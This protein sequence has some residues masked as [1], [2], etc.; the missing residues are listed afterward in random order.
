MSYNPKSPLK[1]TKSPN[2]LN[3]NYTTKPACAL[4][5]PK[6]SE[7]TK[8]EFK[9]ECDINTIMG[10][11]QY[12]GLMPVMN[13][14]APQYLDVS[15]AD[16][17]TAMEFVAGANSLFNDL[18]SSLRNRFNNDPAQF[19]DFC[20]NEA[21][22][23]EMHSLGLLKPEAEWTSKPAAEPAAEPAGTPASI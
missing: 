14:Q 22:R 7:Y 11:Y 18:P 16:F 8:Q 4:A 13:E 6:D 21:N 20:S 1:L 19:L 15:G 9:D 3:S 12:N 17:Q 2:H 10:R 23:S 5:F